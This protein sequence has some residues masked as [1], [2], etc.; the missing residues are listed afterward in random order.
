MDD[1]ESRGDWGGLG[2]LHF[3]LGEFE[4]GGGLHQQALI[5]VGE[6]MAEKLLCLEKMCSSFQLI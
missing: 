5:Y 6:Q 3:I 4:E 2:P 1:L